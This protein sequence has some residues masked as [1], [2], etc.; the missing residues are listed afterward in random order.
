MISAIRKS[1]SRPKSDP[2]L[3][4]GSPKIDC[5]L[6]NRVRYYFDNRKKADSFQIISDRTC[7][8]LDVNELFEYIDRTKT[9]IGQQFLYDRIRTIPNKSYYDSS[10]EGIISKFLS[11]EDFREKVTRILSSLEHKDSYFISQLFCEEQVVLPKWYS[12]L[13]LMPFLILLIVIFTFFLPKLI[14]LL[15]VIMII[16]SIIHYKNQHYLYQ[17]TDSIPQLYKMNKVAAELSK[18]DSLATIN[19]NIDLSIARVNKWRSKMWI[20]SLEKPLENDL[21]LLV[22]GIFE[23]IKILF[24]IEPIVLVGTLK[25][26]E[27]GKTNIQDIFSY[28]GEID[29]LYSISSLRKGQKVHC[30]PDIKYDSPVFEAQ[31]ISHPL[32]YDCIANNIVIKNKPIIITGSNMSGKTSFI[33]SIGT[34]ILTG[35]TLNTCFADSFTFPFSKL[36]SVIR[37]NDNLLDDKS[38][39]FEET[40]AIK[41]VIQES[42]SGYNNI[43]ILDEMFKGTNTIERIAAAKSVLS[44]IKQK[45][46]LVFVTTHDSELVQ[47][48]EN[49]YDFYYFSELVSN[50]EIKFDYKL[51]SGINKSGNAIKILEMNHYPKSV[52]QE[53]FEIVEMLTDKK[54]SKDLNN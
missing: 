2:H 54:N 12:H 28:V 30:V 49:E 8:D 26:L 42:S 43:F 7:D 38:Y 37:I 32:I 31:N 52:T 35:L 51:K 44:Y 9:P 3:I 21:M 53:A 48:L 34:S 22:W 29:T 1:F 27:A 4:F 17:Y 36:F 45:N 39:Y 6:N 10:H 5:E 18:I 16:N 40:L 20:F 19:P 14:F 24:L 23:L 25:C 50:H 46:N 41:E 13:K 47:M 11:D 33:R 15:V